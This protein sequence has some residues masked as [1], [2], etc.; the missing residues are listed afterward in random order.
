LLRFAQ[1][2]IGLLPKRAGQLLLHRPA[3]SARQAMPRLLGPFPPPRPQLLGTNLFAVSRT[4]AKPLRQF[5]EAPST[6]FIP[7]AACDANPNTL[8]AS[9]AFAEFNWSGYNY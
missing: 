9:I 7:P 3:Q 1:G 5:L 2:Q 8:G 4:D 6:A